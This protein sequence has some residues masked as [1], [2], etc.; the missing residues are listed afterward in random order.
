MSTEAAPRSPTLKGRT[1]HADGTVIPLTAKP[2][3]LMDVKVQG[4]QRNKVVFTLPDAQ[5]GS[6]LEYRLNLQYDEDTLMSADWSVQQDYPVMRAHYFF[7]PSTSA[8]ITNGRGETLDRQMFLVT[9]TNSLSVIRDGQG[10]YTLDC[11]DVPAIPDEDWMPP[12]NSVNWRVKFYYT[13]AVSASEFWVNEIRGWQKASDGFAR[14]TKT[15]QGAAAGI[16]GA[17]DSEE[18]K[19]RKLYDAVMKLANTDFT[20]EKSEAERKKE[21]IKPVKDAEG[22]WKQGSGSSN[23]LALLYVALARAAGLTAW[24]M[25][26]VN[27]DRAIFNQNYLSDSQLDD[28]IALVTIGGKEVYLDPGQAKCP[29]GLLAWN[30]TMAGGL[31][32]N[33]SGAVMELTPGNDYTQNLM[34]RNADLT[35]APDGT[36]TGTVKIVMNGQDALKWRQLAV[37]NDVDEVNK[38]FNEWLKDLVPDGVTAE[39]DHLDAL[40][41]YTAS[42]TATVKVSGQLATA[43]GKRLFLP[44]QFFA[45]KGSHPFVAAEYR[46]IPVD[47]HYPQKITDEV[48]YRFPDGVSLDSRPVPDIQQ[49]GNYAQLRV[50]SSSE[51]GAVHVGRV[52]EYGFTM[53][54][55]SGYR[56]LHDFYQKVAADDRQ[57]VVLAKGM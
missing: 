14:P 42:L 9:G 26:V 22:V 32:A 47:V 10:H 51:K 52:I 21:K 5:V 35:L 48:T 54:D 36:V 43:T 7:I 3:D 4:Y 17:G 56:G 20:R 23:E 34:E 37:K 15:L 18:Q 46:A 40:D 28:Y 45:S 29:F 39:L 55:P 31:R 13:H 33:A 53:L 57:Q 11:A 44:G 16:V 1:I 30:H 12:L 2:S 8:Y 50:M 19:A 49:W 27:R 6:I 24:P 41:D 38:Q 25:Q